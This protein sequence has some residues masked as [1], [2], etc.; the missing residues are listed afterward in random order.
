VTTAEDLTI[1]SRS[2]SLRTARALRMSQWFAG[3]RW[4][5]LTEV[6]GT[7]RLPD[8]GKSITYDCG[9]FWIEEPASFQTPL[10]HVGRQ[11][12]T[13]REVDPAD[14]TDLEPICLASFGH[15]TL[16]KA[17]DEYDAIQGELPSPRR[18][19]PAA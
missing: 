10:G 16:V 12:F 7:I 19:A 11:G 13:V 18:K 2:S 15:T 1:R 9:E 3:R 5:I 14:G 6:S 17:R 4:R 8:N